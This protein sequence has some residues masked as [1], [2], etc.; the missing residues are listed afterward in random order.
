MTKLRLLACGVL[1]GPIFTLAWICEGATRSDY[2]GLRHPISSLALG[3]RGWTQAATFLATGALTAAFALGIHRALAPKGGARWTTR[4]VAAAGIGLIGAGL[5]PTDPMNGYPPGTPL[6]PIDWSVTG[7]LHR[8]FSALFF[9]GVPLACFAL[10]RRFA[11]WGSSRW[12]LFSRATALAFLAAF[13]LT[14]A[15]FLHKGPFAEVPGLLQRIAVTVAWLWLTLLAFHLRT[16]QL[17][18][19]R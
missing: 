10:A 11:S 5:F 8:L 14:S 19:A 12:A 4:F 1:A 15:G 13:V 6:L 17:H 2:D 16:D 7:R 18:S 9:L 3:E